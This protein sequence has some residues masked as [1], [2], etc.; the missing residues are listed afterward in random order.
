MNL[1]IAVIDHFLTAFKIT[2]M[3]H[4]L[5]DSFGQKGLDFHQRFLARW[6]VIHPLLHPPALAAGADKVALGAHG[7]WAG[8][9]QEQAHL[10][11]HSLPH[12]LNC[13]GPLTNFTCELG[14]GQAFSFQLLGFVLQEF[15]LLRNSVILHRALQSS[16]CFTLA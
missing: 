12:L 2:L 16:S 8:L 6:A 3:L 14:I 7:D 15:I 4:V 9:G 13:L 1:E 5:D 10:T 11:L